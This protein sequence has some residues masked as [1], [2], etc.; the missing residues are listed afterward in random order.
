[1]L[2]SHA[3]LY[4]K[5]FRFAP[6]SS[7]KVDGARIAAVVEG[8]SSEVGSEEVVDLKGLSLIPGL[9]DIHFHGAVGHDLME[10]TEVALDAIAKYEAKSG[11]TAICPATMTMSEA[12]ITKACANVREYQV[13]DDGADVV[14][15]NMEGPFVSPKKVGAQNPEFV[16]KPD[17]EFFRRCNAAAG[18]KIK[19]LAIAPEEPNAIEVI[20]TLNKEVLSSIA[21]TCCSYDVACEAIAAGATHLTHCYNAMPG[22]AH[23]DPGP[24]AAM[25]DARWG[26]AEIICDGIHIHPAAVRAAFRMMGEERMILISDSMMAVGLDDGTYELG[27]QPVYVK[28]RLATLKSGTIAGSATNLYDCMANAYKT[29]G[30]P[31]ATVI[32]CATYNPARSI[33]V[34]DDYGTIEPGKI[35]SML[36]VDSDLNLK[37]VLLRGKWLFKN[38]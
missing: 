24:I 28:G 17:V 32:R 37:G 25:A 35:A 9:V 1:M 29:M 23:R 26:E 33:K 31:L 6:E 2:L 21:H 20:R 16:H 14:G 12:D 5:D 27:G 8:G 4:T 10:G 30:L 34:L 36:V 38:F 7:V 19:L 15:I 13:K 18:G 3:N 22:L 11:I